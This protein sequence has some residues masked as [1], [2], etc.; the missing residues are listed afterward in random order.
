MK[1]FFEKVKISQMSDSF[2]TAIFVVL[3]GGFQDAYTYMCRDEVFANAQ[4]GNIVLM[5]AHLFQGEFKNCVRYLVPLISFMVGTYVAEHV[6]YYFKYLEKIHWRQIIILCEIVLL[7]SVGFISQKH[8]ALANALVSFVCAMQVQTFH[9][10]RGQV[11]A[12]TMCIG[13]MRSAIVSLFAY[14]QYKDKKIREKAIV[15]FSVIGVF[16]IGAG[17]GSVVTKRL[18]VKAIWVCCALLAVSFF[19]MFIDLELNEKRNGKSGRKSKEEIKQKEP[20]TNPKKT[21]THMD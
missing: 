5:S 12:S 6:H 4:T 18:G 20:N 21:N 8:N 2:I 3:S 15:Y 19:M 17:L 13:N 9:K 10:V 11:Y 16:A 1:S 7:F 14:F